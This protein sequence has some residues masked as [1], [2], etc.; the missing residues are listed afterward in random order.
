MKKEIQWREVGKRGSGIILEEVCPG[1][2]LDEMF[3]REG[4]PAVTQPVKQPSLGEA[5]GRLQ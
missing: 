2:I 3:F 5:V 1:E 4:S